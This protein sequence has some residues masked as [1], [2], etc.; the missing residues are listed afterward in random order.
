L[1]EGRKLFLTVSKESILAYAITDHPTTLNYNEL[2]IHTQY[3]VIYVVN[4]INNQSDWTI[5]RLNTTVEITYNVRQL[6]PY[7]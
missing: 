7:I 6:T 1:I 2:N 5:L 4:M 3:T